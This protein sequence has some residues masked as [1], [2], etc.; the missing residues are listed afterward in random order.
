VILFIGVMVVVVHHFHQTP[1]HFNPV[2]TQRVEASS[3]AG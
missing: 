2:E 1:V 3:H